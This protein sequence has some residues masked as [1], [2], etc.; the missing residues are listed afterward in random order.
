[1]KRQLKPVGVGPL[2][3]L[4]SCEIFLHSPKGSCAGGGYLLQPSMFHGLLIGEVKGAELDLISDACDDVLS[5]VDYPNAPAIHAQ[6]KG[7]WPD[8]E[9]RYRHIGAVPNA[10]GR[11]D[12]QTLSVQDQLSCE[13]LC[14]LVR[15]QCPILLEEVDLNIRQD[16]D[17]VDSKD[18]TRALPM[19]ALGVPAATGYLISD[20]GNGLPRAI[21]DVYNAAFN[22]GLCSGFTHRLS[23]VQNSETL[24]PSLE[25][26][27]HSYRRKDG[28]AGPTLL[29]VREWSWA[30][31]FVVTVRRVRSGWPP[32]M[33]SLRE[34]CFV[35]DGPGPGRWGFTRRFGLGLWVCA[36]TAFALPAG[37]H[38]AVFA[39][40]GGMWRAWVWPARLRVS[41]IW[42]PA[43]PLSSPPGAGHRGLDL[44]EM[45]LFSA[46]G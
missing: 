18:F 34:A 46:S 35:Q 7:A 16:F 40:P 22:M 10:K 15:R 27:M 26:I 4:G 13:A 3:G 23:A 24:V 43:R 37:E 38:G 17:M 36:S 21:A 25:S 44:L 14:L 5:C 32:S 8:E 42:R 29:Y 11:I 1:M 9:R 12:L 33:G 30:L 6:G 41:A 20:S 45:G 19:L 28:L 39:G 2:A 31:W